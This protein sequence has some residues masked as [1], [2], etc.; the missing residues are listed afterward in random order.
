M[1]RE[2]KPLYRH[3]LNLI[4][5]VYMLWASKAFRIVRAFG[6][7]HNTPLKISTFF[8]SISD[9]FLSIH[10]SNDLSTHNQISTTVNELTESFTAV[11]CKDTRVHLTARCAGL[12]KIY[13]VYDRKRT[14]SSIDNRGSSTQG[15]RSACA[16]CSYFSNQ[17]A[18]FL[19]GAREVE[20]TGLSLCNSDSN[21]VN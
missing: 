6:G 4:E 2:S 16:I 15:R 9:V 20:P 14:I 11:K 7:K 5:P 19:H 1:P 10:P 12:L 8:L 13:K 21:E 3:L 18:C 17:I